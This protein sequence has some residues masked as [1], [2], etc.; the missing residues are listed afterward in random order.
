M[1]ELTTEDTMY[2]IYIATTPEKVW[3]ALT[4]SAFTTKFF[5][6]RTVES[7]WKKGSKWLLRMPD[8]RVDVVGV[9]RE[10][11][12]P[13]KLVLSWNVDWLPEKLPEAIVTYQI[14]AAGDGLVRLN[15][16]EAHPTAIPKNLL[17]GGRKG[18]PMILS[19]LKSL[20]ETGKSLPTPVP[21]PPKELQK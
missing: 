10:S 11:D 9:V 6:G 14:E 7:D 3:T 2:V 18:W 8:G 12:P 15:M 21:Q 1:T 19:G 13:R 20:L 4:S 5:F 16:T 17:E